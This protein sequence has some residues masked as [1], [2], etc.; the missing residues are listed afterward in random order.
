MI[1]TTNNPQSKC[2]TPSPQ[3]EGWGGAVFT[4]SFDPF[5]I[6]HADIVSRA[7]SLFSKII[8]GVG[9]NERKTYMT[10]T[11]ERVRTIAQL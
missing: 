3:G 6:G 10:P 2:F 1:T 9:H 4:G 8:I 5:T 7:L 11:E